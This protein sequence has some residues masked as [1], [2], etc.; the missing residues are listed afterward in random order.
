MI[1][2]MNEKLPYEEQLDQVW[3]DLPLP[4][5]DMAWKDMKRRLDEDD[6]DKIVVPPPRRGCGIGALLIGLLLLGSLWFLLRPGIWFTKKENETAQQTKNNVEE[7]KTEVKT[8]SNA[9]DVEDEIQDKQDRNID[10]ITQ[11]D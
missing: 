2:L 4:N 5:E 11:K 7:S 10:K 8:D 6:D 1:G 9:S 3:D